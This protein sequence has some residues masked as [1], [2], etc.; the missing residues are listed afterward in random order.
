MVHLNLEIPEDFFDE[1][2]RCGYLVT[3]KMK[4]IWAV[5]LD[6][7]NEFIRVCEK[8]HIEYFVDGGTMLGAVRHKGF[9]PWDDDI[10]IVMKRKDYDRLN[11]IAEQEFLSPYFWQTEKTDPGSLRGHAQLRNSETT[12]ILQTEIGKKW[13]F[14]QGVFI[15][16]FPLDNIP[17]DEEERITFF[18]GLYKE[19]RLAHKISNVTNR[20][21]KNEGSFV[22]K[23]IKAICHLLLK[24]SCNRAYF[25]FEKSMQKYDNLSTKFIGKLFFHPIVPGYIWE[26][27]WFEHK[28]VLPFEML[29]VV[30]SANYDE[31]MTRFYGEWK[32]PVMQETTHGGVL[33][34]TNIGYK[35]YLKNESRG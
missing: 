14:N 19:F 11:E 13:T 32:T 3:C 25:K 2:V 22:K 27:R 16:I 31:I 29:N 9:I 12:A 17:D 30:V 33:F 26:K 1:E 35:E 4:E 15:D 21:N 7:L 23:R 28:I 5:E 18:N 20:Y 34:D 10:D 24:N 6:L 8:Y